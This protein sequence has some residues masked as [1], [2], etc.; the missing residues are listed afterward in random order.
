MFGV[1]PTAVLG[2]TGTVWMLGVEDVFRYGRQLL[3]QGPGIIACWLETF[4]VLEN[5]VAVE[6]HQAIRLLRHWDFTIGDEIEVHRGVEFVRFHIERA[7][8]QEARIAA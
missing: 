2:G 7:A 4:S 3:V 5:V 6:N 1:V 8:I